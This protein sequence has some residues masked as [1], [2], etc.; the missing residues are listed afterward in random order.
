MLENINKIWRGCIKKNKTYLKLQEL[1]ISISYKNITFPSCFIIWANIF[2][3]ETYSHLLIVYKLL[4]NSIERLKERIF[5]PLFQKKVACFNKI[6]NLF[7]ND[8]LYFPFS[9]LK[10]YNLWSS[11]N[12]TLSKFFPYNSLF[13]RWVCMPWVIW[14]TAN[15]CGLYLH[16]SKKM[17]LKASKTKVFWSLLKSE[18]FWSE[19]WSKTSMGTD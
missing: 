5:E 15:H 19:Y 10:I 17:E 2:S 18:N 7:F 4:N 9:P 6:D 1:N 8:L 13:V 11:V 3:S 16:K 14:L 12:Y